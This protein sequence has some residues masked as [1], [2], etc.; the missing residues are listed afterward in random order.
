M[1][2]HKLVAAFGIGIEQP[3]MAIATELPGSHHMRL[4][5]KELKLLKIQLSSDSR[6]NLLVILISS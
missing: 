5:L 4:L 3:P 1:Y 2:V 6:I